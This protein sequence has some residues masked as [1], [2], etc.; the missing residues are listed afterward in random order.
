MLSQAVTGANSY[1]IDAKLNAPFAK[2]SKQISCTLGA[3][4]NG[5][6]AQIDILDTL[7]LG[8][9]ATN[10]AKGGIALEGVY[11]PVGGA[12]AAITIS[13]NCVTAGD[14]RTLSHG[15]MSIT[16]VDALTQ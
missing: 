15:R 11:T 6:F 3:L 7:L 13:V 5:V 10:T 4:E 9:D 14:T 8:S 2:G 16:G 1:M 12:T